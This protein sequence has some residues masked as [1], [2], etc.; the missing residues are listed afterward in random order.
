MAVATTRTPN[1]EESRIEPKPADASNGGRGCTS[2]AEK[3]KAA[4][5][6]ANPQEHH[7]QLLKRIARYLVD[8]PRVV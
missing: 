7:L 1:E 2:N 6:R 3:T 8:A 4:R 5:M